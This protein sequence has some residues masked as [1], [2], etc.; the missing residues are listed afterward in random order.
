MPF[1]ECK[2]SHTVCAD[3]LTVKR[4]TESIYIEATNEKDAKEKAGHPRNWLRSAAIFG[5]KP[6][7][8]LITVGE[9][10]RLDDDETKALKAVN[11]VP[12]KSRHQS[13][14]RT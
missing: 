14:R 3:D 5:N 12:V 8:F 13:P 7:S 2:I 6:S 10:R 11:P 1:F 9:C 4:L